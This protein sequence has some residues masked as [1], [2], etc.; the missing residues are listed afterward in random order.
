VL[1]RP[2][3][4]ASSNLFGW[5]TP[6]SINNAVMRLPPESLVL[7]DLIQLTGER[8]P[9]PEW[10]PLKKKIYQRGA[11]L[12][13]R[14]KRAEDLAWGTFGPAALTHYLSRRHLASHALP[15][16]AFYPI[17]W[18]EVSLFFAT[19]DAVSSRLTEKTIGVHLWSTSILKSPNGQTWRNAL[20]R[21]NSWLGAMCER[22]GVGADRP[23]G[24]TTSTQKH[25]YDEEPGSQA[26]YA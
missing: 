19:P 11:A 14:H 4:H 5:E 9:V 25:R 3:S 26:A 24:L 21:A 15:I 13:G 10:W 1:L 8:A 6:T 16:E 20:P 23:V 12:I 7:D 18:T 2:L 17:N 22:Y